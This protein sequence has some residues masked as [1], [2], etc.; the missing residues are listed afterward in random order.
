MGFQIL[1]RSRYDFSIFRIHNNSRLSI[2]FTIEVRSWLGRT[3]RTAEETGHGTLPLHPPQ[4][5]HW[6]A[7]HLSRGG[8]DGR[9]GVP[10][11]RA[12]RNSGIIRGVPLIR[13]SVC[14]GPPSPRGRLSGDRKGRPYGMKWSRGVG[15]AKPGAEVKPQYL[16]FLQPQ[17]PVGRIELRNATQILR[18]G[19]IARPAK[20]A[21][22][23][24]GSGESG[25]MGTKCPSAASPAILWFLSHRWERNSPR[26]AKSP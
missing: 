7:F 14:T 23:V 10:P 12:E 24:M 5:T 18:A 25:H 16:E 15:S 21:S 19:N 13:S 6:G 1:F 26:R 4:C 8:P 2:V 22:P 11:L 20:Y 17:A 3:I 9:P